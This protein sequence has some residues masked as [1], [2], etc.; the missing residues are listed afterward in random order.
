MR[1]FI[2]PVLALVLVIGLALPAA[3]VMADGA[4]I[5]TDKPDYAP[6]ET[7]VISGS[8]FL[9]NIEVSVSVE[10]PDGTV[11]TVVATTDDTG[12]F[13]CGYLLDGI[14]GTYVVTANDGTNEASTTF[15]DTPQN[16]IVEFATSGLPAGTSITVVFDYYN[17]GG[18][19][20]Y[21]SRT[22][23]SPGPFGNVQTKPDSEFNFSFPDPVTVGS[24]TYNLVS[25]A[26]DSPFNTGPA[27]QTTTVIATYVYDEGGAQ[28]VTE[29]TTVIHNA[30]DDSVIDEGSS[31]DLA[32]IVYDVATVKGDDPTG[33][34]DFTL[35][36]V[37]G[38]FDPKSDPAETDD[39]VIY[40]DT[41]V[42]L[43]SGVATS[44]DSPQLH[45]GDYYWV[46]SYKG[47]SGNEP[48]D[49]APEPFT[50]EKANVTINTTIYTENDDE[51]T[52]E[53]PI[54]STTIIYDKVTVTGIGVTGFEPAGT[55]AFTYDSTAAGSPDI[56]GDDPATAYSDYVGPLSAGDYT[57]VASYTDTS[58]D[59]NDAD[60]DDED[61]SVLEVN[62]G[63]NG[64]S[65]GYWTNK[66][67]QGMLTTTGDRDFLD[68]EA[69]FHTFTAYPKEPAWPSGVTNLNLMTLSQ[70]KS[71][72]KSFINNANA[73]DMRYMLAAQLLAVK[74]DSRHDFLDGDNIWLDDGD[75]IVQPDEVMSIGELF[76]AADNAWS[77]TDRSEQEYFKDVLEGICKNTV[78]FIIP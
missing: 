65:M 14:T 5:S 9:A 11:E 70:F 56:S 18:N 1:K 71:W 68:L 34:V 22:F 23:N 60:S 41:D 46:A 6:E 55:V 61:F 38:Q 4:T 33:Y 40:T 24:D 37:V 39:E 75:G 67:G 51:V 69:P 20:T 45:A 58:G 74:L 57:F 47:D 50:V 62:L 63:T 27:N 7:V 35:Y 43:V 8:G 76:D 49:S 3:A 16:H 12:S 10:R 54:A 42:A 53:Y 78:W 30:A 28:E 72:V 73:E 29:T 32:T 25:T 31:V 77:G 26:P 36:K 2:Y 44:G 21:G 15:T 48:S 59:Y 17:P 66:N 52:G 19:H 13:T 64:K